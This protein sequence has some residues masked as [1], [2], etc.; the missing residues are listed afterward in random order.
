MRRIQILLI[1]LLTILFAV[2]CAGKDPIFNDPSTSKKKKEKVYKVNK[3]DIDMPVYFK[4]PADKKNINLNFEKRGQRPVNLSLDNVYDGLVAFGDRNLSAP[5]GSFGIVVDFVNGALYQMPSD[6]VRTVLNKFAPDNS[7]VIK[8]ILSKSDNPIYTRMVAVDAQGYYNKEELKFL[9]LLNGVTVGNK[10][11]NYQQT[12]SDK[13]PVIEVKPEQNGASYK[14]SLSPDKQIINAA[15]NG[16]FDRLINLIN[17]GGNINETDPYNGDNALIASIIAGDGKIADLLMEKGINVKHKNNNGQ[18]PLH[19]AAN[20]GLY[21]I[22]KKL[23]RKGLKVNDKDNGGNTA[24][25][26]ASAAPYKNMVDLLINSGANIEDKNNQGETPLLIAARTGN[27]ETVKN[28]IDNGAN[29]NATDNNGNN[30]VMKAVQNKNSY[31][32]QELINEKVDPNKPNNDKVTPLMVAIANNDINLTDT[33]LKNGIDV[34]QTDSRGRTPLMN[35]TVNGNTPLVKQIL[36]YNPDLQV[37]D[38]KDETAFDLAKNRGYAQIQRIIGQDI[39]KLELASIDLF[40]SVAKNDQQESLKLIKSGA[41]PNSRDKE[42]GNTPIF[43]AVANNYLPMTNFLLDNGADPNVQNNKGNT[44]LII[45]ITSA[46]INMIDLLI[47]KKA[48]VN[49]ANNNGDTALLWATKLKNL[50][51]VRKLLM[52]G[53]DP[54]MKNNEGVSPFLIAYNEGTPEILS[55]LKAAGGYK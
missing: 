22:A 2:S 17:S 49:I 15:V 38:N 53:A 26:Y 3:K 48:N 19:I 46:D 35:A 27:T 25:M 11:V 9:P 10:R 1:S 37:T 36:E 7:T 33:L 42:T 47:Q 44:P 54:N 24:L 12:T 18:S 55:L 16:Q 5:G 39:K 43:T 14:S 4:I 20:Y 30:A 50:E 34:N 29:K 8:E 23:L 40:S 21:D 45:A 32:T 52:S 6:D 28:L 13:K 31:T 51:M 41:N